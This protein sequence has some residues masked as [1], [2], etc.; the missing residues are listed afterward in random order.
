MLTSPTVFLKNATLTGRVMYAGGRPAA[1]IKV[2]VGLQGKAETDLTRRTPESAWGAIYKISADETVTKP[3]GSYHSEVAANLPYNVMVNMT[4]PGAEDDRTVGWVAA[5]NEGVIGKAGKT[6]LLPD[7]VLTR[8][9]FVTGLV[10]DK[11]SG[12]PLAGVHIGSHGPHRPFTTGMITGTDTDPSGHYRLRLAP[13][14]GEVY[15]AD[16]RYNGF[17]DEEARAKKLIVPVTTSKGHPATVNFQVTP[18][19]PKP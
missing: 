2:I 3:D 12:R 18:S 15:I 16:G 4:R 8:G 9:V 14:K 13:G 5:A 19:P 10:T 1:G 7:L 6:T 11:A 17:F